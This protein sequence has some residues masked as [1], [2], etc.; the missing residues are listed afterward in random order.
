SGKSAIQDLISQIYPIKTQVQTV[1]GLTLID[2][3]NQQNNIYLQIPS[4]ELKNL[5]D[6]TIQFKNQV[7]VIS[8]NNDQNSILPLQNNTFSQLAL[9]VLQLA[10][11]N[12]D[13]QNSTN[14]VIN[15][16]QNQSIQQVIF[17]NITISLQCFG[18]NQIIISNIQQVVFQNIRE[19]TMGAYLGPGRKSFFLDTFYFS[20]LFLGG[21]SLE[22][23]KVSRKKLFLPGPKQAPIVNSLSNKTLINGQRI[24]NYYEYNPETLAYEINDQLTIKKSHFRHTQDG[25]QYIK[26]LVKPRKN[27]NHQRF[28]AI[29]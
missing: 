6:Q 19:L 5:I 12:F 17:Q 7:L 15:I 23:Q 13:F 11:F 26:N 20:R 2:K 1:D 9:S 10:N 25:D 28:K 16:T 22:K 29:L 3:Q 8:S 14:L 21:K 4:Y 24:V 27:L 18:S